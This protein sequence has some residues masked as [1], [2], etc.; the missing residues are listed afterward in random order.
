[1]QRKPR[2]RVNRDEDGLSQ[3]MRREIV[4]DIAFWCVA[5]LGATMLVVL[6]GVVGGA[7]PI[8][9]SSTDDNGAVAE[10]T[11]APATPPP[12]AAT[13][14]PKEPAKAP[15]RTVSAQTATQ[16][17]P[18]PPAPPAEAIIVVTAARGDSWFSARL[19]SEEGRVLDERVLAQGESV[20]L[21][22]PRIWLSVGAAGNVDLTVNGKPRSISPGTVELVLTRPPS[23]AS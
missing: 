12:K 5:A 14:A 4:S 19:G 11:A 20:R 8:D 13:T 3:P 23:A 15:D 9:S 22:G 7:I 2:D 18:T 17:K 10:S 6:L 1:M 21:E 16:P